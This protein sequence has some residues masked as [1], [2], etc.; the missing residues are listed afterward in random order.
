MAKK[1]QSN[2]CGM[3]KSFRSA[4]SVILRMLQA[5]VAG[6]FSRPV[7]RLG[8]TPFWQGRLKLVRVKPAGRWRQGRT[9]TPSSSPPRRFVQP[10]TALVSLTRSAAG[11]PDLLAAR[12]A[13]NEVR[14]RSGLRG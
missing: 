1:I 4:L 11:M 12:R 13:A 3:L 5:E 14:W 9:D 2:I 8:V 10:D 6:S 7:N